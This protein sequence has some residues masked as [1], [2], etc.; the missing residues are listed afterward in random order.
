MWL[1][2]LKRDYGVTEKTARRFAAEGKDFRSLYALY[3]RSRV[4]A[5]GAVSKS[6]LAKHV[7]KSERLRRWTDSHA[8]K[9]FFSLQNGHT[10]TVGP[11]MIVSKHDIDYSSHFGQVLHLNRCSNI[12]VEGSARVFLPGYFKVV[13]RLKLAPDYE[14]IGPLNFLAKVIYA[15]PI[16]H[17][18]SDME[19]SRK[20]AWT[21]DEII[22]P[23][24]ADG[25]HIHFIWNPPNPAPI[26]NAVQNPIAAMHVNDRPFGALDPAQQRQDDG[27]GVDALRDIFELNNR[28]RERLRREAEA[29]GARMD[30]EL[31][32][33][34]ADEPPQNNVDD[35]LM[36]ELEPMAEEEAPRPQMDASAAFP[37]DEYFDFL[38]GFIHVPQAGDYVCFA[39]TN[40]TLGFKY[41]LY[42]DYVALVPVAKAEYDLRHAFPLGPMLLD[43]PDYWD[44]LF[45]S[46]SYNTKRK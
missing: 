20:Y 28:I 3:A 13:F 44:T 40:F 23:I 22:T 2:M 35:D 36:P 21:E 39:L 41:G 16:D 38:A 4:S 11:R 8:L 19:K 45:D 43:G 29:G 15:D 46:A 5:T 42:L 1:H 34:N 26:A 17:L 14:D 32:R 30:D 25:T 7:R 6:V 33:D 10:S 24:R 37:I 27:F 9:P 31:E 12:Q 18:L